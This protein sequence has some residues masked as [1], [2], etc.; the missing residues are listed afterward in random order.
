MDFGKSLTYPFDDSEW[1]TKFLI[2]GLLSLIPIVNLIVLG[3][4]LKVIK[5]VAEGVEHPLPNWDDFEGFFVAGLMATLATVVWA[6]P[7]FLLGAMLAV[8]AAISRNGGSQELSAFWVC[9]MGVSCLMMLYGLFVGAL[10]PAAYTKYAISGQIAA[11]F[12]LADIW[13]FISDNLGNYVISLL[14]VCVASLIAS[15]GV[16]ACGIGIVF[17]EFWSM[18]VGPYLWGQMARL[19]LTPA[20]VLP[21][22]VSEV[23]L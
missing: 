2:G 1:V 8:T 7:M 21:P 10:L 20:E 3:Y 16:I 4:V 13:Q 23:T 19:S 18:L 11:F 22:P 12:R 6:L 9:S 17:T 15:L 5:N 14:F